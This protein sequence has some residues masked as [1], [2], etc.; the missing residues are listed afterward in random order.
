MRGKQVSTFSSFYLLAALL[1]K[2]DIKFLALRLY[3]QVNSFCLAEIKRF[4]VRCA[5]TPSFK[6]VLIDLKKLIVRT[7]QKIK[8]SSRRFVIK[9][10]Q[11]MPIKIDTGLVLFI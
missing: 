9:L 3:E 7:T 11:Q 10:K 8:K 5:K 2:E 6:I 1:S 4:F